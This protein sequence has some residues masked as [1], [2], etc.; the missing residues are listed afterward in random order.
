MRTMG[1]RGKHVR[2]WDTWDDDE[3]STLLDM[4]HEFKR[5]WVLESNSS[6]LAGRTLYLYTHNPILQAMD[7]VAPAVGQLGGHLV[8]LNRD[9]MRCSI[10][11]LPGDVASVL[12]RQG[13]AILV[14]NTADNQ[15]DAFI[16]ELGQ[17]A[18]IP[19]ISVLSDVYDP[20]QAMA[21]MMTLQE[22]VS[23]RL[24]GTKIA[25]VWIYTSRT[26]SSIAAAHS[27]LLLAARFGM[28]VAI[29]NPPEFPLLRTVV[30]KAK[31]YCQLSGGKVQ[32][33]ESMEDALENAQ[34]VVPVHWG[35]MADGEFGNS[36]NK[37]PAELMV[38]KEKYQ[39]WQMNQ[40]NMCLADFDARM[41]YPLPWARGSG[42]ASEV[43][44]G[45]NSLIYPFMENRLHV[46]KAILALT[47]AGRC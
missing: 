5:R 18:A 35:V 31:N 26:G 44:D 19:T 23:T 13:H 14:Q 34:V 9:N 41:L 1:F 33:A 22:T 15:G 30:H 27:L 32:R 24:A 36:D 42:V 46:L 43:M 6:L 45:P 10:G 20:I 25:L 47:V 38:L 4:V 12:S 17:S 3:I 8:Q 2:T 21:A 16:A 28:E 37:Q 40:D 7:I 39:H 11:E 29:A